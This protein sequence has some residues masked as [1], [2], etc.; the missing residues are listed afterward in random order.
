MLPSSGWNSSHSIGHIQP[1]NTMILQVWPFPSMPV[2]TRTAWNIFRLGDPQKN[3]LT[4]RNSTWF[5]MYAKNL[6]GNFLG[7][8]MGTYQPGP[9]Q[10][11]VAFFFEEIT[12]NYHNGGYHSYNPYIHRII[13][14]SSFYWGSLPQFITGFWGPSCRRK[15][16]PLIPTHSSVL[17]CVVHGR[18][19][20][21]RRGTQERRNMGKSNGKS[22]PTWISEIGKVPLEDTP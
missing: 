13:T 4:S 10:C 6:G 22:S 16:F 21:W 20:A 12:Q 9:T 8:K 17:C 2:T 14:T 11:T 3:P 18:G 15:W 1:R 19:E 5:K 7:K